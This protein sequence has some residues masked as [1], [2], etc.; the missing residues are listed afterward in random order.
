M[1]KVTFKGVWSHSWLGTEWGRSGELPTVL[2]V[3]VPCPFPS[4]EPCFESSLAMS[5]Q[6]LLLQVRVTTGS[7]C[8]ARTPERSDSGMHACAGLCPWL[9]LA[10]GRACAWERA[11]RTHVGHP[12][13]DGAA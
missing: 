7:H 13:K 5:G 12:N 10:G 1:A 8:Q 6:V 9:P 3:Q 11:A 2:P 4:V